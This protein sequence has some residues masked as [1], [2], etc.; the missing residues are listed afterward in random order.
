MS[1][2][3]GGG[4]AR[5]PRDILRELAEE[6][7]RGLEGLAFRVY[8]PTEPPP[9][10][11]AL[12]WQRVND[13]VVEVV[14]THGSWVVAEG[15]YVAVRTA[16]AGASPGYHLREIV[17]DERDRIF[18]RIGLDEGPAPDLVLESEI[19]ITVDGT[20]VRAELRTE[21]RLWA[22]RLSLGGP[23]AS[24]DLGSGL[25]SGPGDPSGEPG[26]GPVTVTVT[27][28]GIAP[29]RVGLRSVDQFEPYALGRQLEL[30]KLREA[31]E[32]RPHVRERE[33]APVQGLEAHRELIARSIRD[34]L[35]MSADL[36]AG[37]PPRRSRSE[38]RDTG[39]LWER[40][41]RQQMRLSGDDHQ[42]A[43]LAVT[44]LVNQLVSLAEKADW[45]SDADA[46]GAAVE[47]SIRHAV[48]DSEV[49][50][51]EAQRAWLA[52]W[53][54]GTEGQADLHRLGPKGIRERMHRRMD[55]RTAWLALWRQ[56]YEG[57]GAC[58]S[59]GAEGK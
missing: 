38:P 59:S 45:F 42:T 34:A 19:W 18:G 3:A 28:R 11:Q 14:L 20:P 29:E 56:W 48:F 22:A 44:A 24:P 16:T 1:V 35:R 23:G 15:P 9:D 21:G 57:R 25:H 6:D 31:T 58:K 51:I 47:E 33:L 43:N 26:A 41:V 32:D 30:A 54:A 27:G 37:R 39:E 53:T 52:D 8:G 40:T 17:E 13:Q 49:P 50:S 12:S 7:L 5:R 4:R 46:A 10:A 55:A 2:E 36:E